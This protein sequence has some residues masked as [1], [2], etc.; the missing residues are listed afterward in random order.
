MQYAC[1]KGEIEVTER[2]R[3]DP[4]SA[5][6]V[7]IYL[8]P[9]SSLFRKQVLQAPESVFQVSESFAEFK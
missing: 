6:E 4:Q 9:E 8:P 1:D 2:R 3:T 5:Q 7:D